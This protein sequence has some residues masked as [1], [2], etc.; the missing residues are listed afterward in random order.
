M[1]THIRTEVHILPNM[2]ESFYKNIMTVDS[3]C[4]YYIEYIFEIRSLEI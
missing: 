2:R 3:L 4:S 1:K